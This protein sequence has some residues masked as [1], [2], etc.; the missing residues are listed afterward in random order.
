M[1]F[2]G[3]V[4]LLVVGVAIVLVVKGWD[5]RLVLLAAAL[6]IATVAE[7]TIT[8]KPSS[9]GGPVARV[10]QTFLAT[11]SN[12]KF[13]VPICTAM[14]FAH[15]LKHTGCERHLVLLL[16]HPLRYVRGLMVPGVIVVGF[17]VNIPLVSQTSTAVCL[18]AVVVPLMRAAGYS[19]ATIGA[20]LLLGASVGGELLNPGA[21]ELLTVANLT[22]VPTIVQTQ[23]YLPALVFTQLAI[24]TAVIWLMSVWWE[25]KEPNPLTPFPKKEGGAEPNAQTSAPQASVLSPSPF[26]GGVGEGLQ[27]PPERINVLKA[28]VPLVPLA[29][30]FASAM[31]A[32]YNLFEIPDAWVVPKKA[33]GSR[34]P[35]YNSRLIGF[36]MLIGVLVAAAV[37]PNKARDCVKEFFSGAGYGFANIVSL[38]VIANCFG[39][40]IK[41]A[42]LAEAL[43]TLIKSAPGLM[44]PLAALVPLVFAAICGS[45]M[46][47]T[48]SL[49]GFFHGPAEA[50]G[51]D[52]VAVGAMVSLGSAAG[53][54]MSPVAAVVL[55]CA[56]LTGT[57]PF[58]LVKRVAVPLLVGIAIVVLL[59]LAGVL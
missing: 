49:Y 59:R 31:P 54:T 21:P 8:T 23:R 25:R 7:V 58:T 12:E 13:V 19:M 32:P 17:L 9:T 16:V 30:L 20:C 33:D 11:F 29:L 36:A 53:R 52:P 6:V 28:L 1:E 18:G 40:A 46:A 43:G 47:S 4:A 50:L 3:A 35:A 38:I 14:G 15:V 27:P 39:E 41:A 26:R 24:S 5:V 57:N 2:A 37:T 51:L 48:Q 44:Q 55:M 42:G 34:D 10:L 56:T 22:N 45:G